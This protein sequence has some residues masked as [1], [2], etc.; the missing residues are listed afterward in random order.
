MT[1]PSTTSPTA[2]T[3]TPIAPVP[4]DVVLA[5][6]EA[7][8]DRL[9]RIAAEHVPADD[10]EDAVQTALADI[11]QTETA[12]RDPSVI[13]PWLEN[14]VRHHA[15]K[16]HRSRQRDQARSQ[17]FLDLDS[18]PRPTSAAQLELRV[19]LARALAALP[20][21]QRRAVEAVVVHGMTTRELAAEEGVSHVAIHKRVQAG[22][23]ALRCALG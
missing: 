6:A 8:R 4:F 14:A 7:H 23:A 22:L 9:V 1:T 15:I 20:D 18:S 19:D 5:V 13:L 12:P 21:D 3:T 16:H 11:V 2:P 10:A 17:A